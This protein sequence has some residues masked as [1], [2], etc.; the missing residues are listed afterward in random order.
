[1][2]E[3]MNTPKPVLQALLLAEHVYQD[4][5]TGKKIIAGTFNRLNFSKR[6]PPPPALPLPGSPPPEGDVPP[7]AP[8]EGTEL[9]NVISPGSPFAFITLT[10]VHGTIP[11]ELRYV[12]L[13]NN[14]VLLTTRFQVSCDDP[15]NTLE[16]TVPIPML[17]APHEG[18][19]AL[20]LLHSDEPLGTMRIVA[21]E[22]SG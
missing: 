9:H 14:V 11:L 18:V 21:V 10:D 20:E 16:L 19:Y 12:D 5:A 13:A 15:L 22:N 6:R 8:P 2:Q 3:P 17:P 1:M 4:R 7:A